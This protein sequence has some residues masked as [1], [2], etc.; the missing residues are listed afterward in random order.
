MPAVRGAVMARRR[1][2]RPINGWIA[3]DKPQGWTSSKAVGRVKHLIQA[4]KVG[5]GGTLDP[6]ATGILPLA[7]GEA[8]KTVAYVMDAAKRYRFTMRFGAATDT[9]DIEGTVIETD[10]KRPDD[11]AISALLPGFTGE[12]DQTPPAYAAVKINGERA[13]DIARR[14]ET[15][16]LPSRKVR[17]DELTFV[18]RIDADHAEF[19]MACGKGTYVRSI[20]RDLGRQLGCFAHVAS[21]RRLAVGQFDEDNAVTLEALEQ[22]VENDSLHQLI[23]PVTTA[24]ADIPA[25]AVTEPQ[26]HRLRSGQAIRIGERLISADI[27]EGRTVQAVCH[28]ALVALTRFEAGELDPMRVFNN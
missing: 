19:E 9:D 15:I 2:G 5:H 11:A 20:A 3:I 8:T 24:L 17:V 6:L 16:D 25:F 21:L 18:R 23:I 12:I 13:Y 26:A 27:A 1:K 22:V 10:E 28:G 4:Q 14:G 7:C